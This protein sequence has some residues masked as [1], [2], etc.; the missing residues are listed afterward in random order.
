MDIPIAA[1]LTKLP[2]ILP[3]VL[4]GQNAASRRRTASRRSSSDTSSYTVGRTSQLVPD[5]SSCSVRLSCLNRR[6]RHQLASRSG[7]PHREAPHTTAPALSG[8]EPTA[9]TW[10]LPAAAR[11]ATYFAA[12]PALG[13]S[14]TGKRVYRRSHGRRPQNRH[15]SP[16]QRRAA[17]P[18][19]FV[20]LPPPQNRPGDEVE[21]HLQR[22]CSS[23]RSDLLLVSG[24]TLTWVVS[25]MSVA[26]AAC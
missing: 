11:P 10:P 15:R 17:L 1:H 16:R 2:S 21:R 4:C 20:I 18:A 12:S 23:G 5:S 6:L 22:G 25:V 8:P 14:R 3:S 26:A 19:G 24:F 13:P 7:I 9:S